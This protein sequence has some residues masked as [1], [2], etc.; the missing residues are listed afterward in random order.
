M[1]GPSI[2]DQQV[3]D[4][5]NDELSAI[6]V[7]RRVQRRAIHEPL[8]RWRDVQMPGL[9]VALK[10]AFGT[11]RVVEPQRYNGMAIALP[12]RVQ[13]RRLSPW[14]LLAA[15]VVAAALYG[16][17]LL[18][19]LSGGGA[20]VAQLQTPTLRVSLSA[21]SYE[22]GQAVTGEVTVTSTSATTL[23]ELSV[24]IFPVGALRAGVDEASVRTQL[25]V[26]PVNSST[27]AGAS[28]HFQFVWDQRQKDGT[29]AP[30]GDYVVT[31]RLTSRT[32]QG[33]SHAATTGL[34]N[35]VTVAL[36]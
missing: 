9:L 25:L 1:N 30:R 24:S 13:R 6:R 11:H 10:D 2:S 33:N 16:P 17:P 3:I 26:I 29:L 31:A 14:L 12:I 19:Q 18:Q 35:E 8:R 34:A 5:L 23:Q 36:R 32:D 22:V 15:L 7:P 28:K 4:R 20:Q 21:T 27:V